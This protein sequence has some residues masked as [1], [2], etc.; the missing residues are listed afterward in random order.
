MKAGMFATK[1]G[2]LVAILAAFLTVEF[3]SYDARADGSGSSWHLNGA[4]NN[5]ARIS[6]NDATCLSAGW[7]NS[8]PASSGVVGGS[9][10]WAR[11]DCSDYGTVVAHLDFKNNVDNHARL[12]GSNRI[13]GD[14]WVNKVRQI[15]C[16]IDESALCWKDQV[17]PKT[18]GPHTGWVRFVIIEGSSLSHGVADVRT[19]QNRYD[20]CQEYPDVIY[21]S[22]DPEGDAH[23]DPNTAAPEPQ[24]VASLDPNTASLEDLRARPCGGEGQP[25]CDCGNRR[26]DRGDCQWS[27]EQSQAATQGE[28]NAHCI[29]PTFEFDDNARK[30][31]IGANCKNGV[32]SEQEGG[33]W[34][35]RWQNV[36]W[37]GRT[38]YADDVLVCWDADNVITLSTS[39][40]GTCG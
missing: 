20:F 32:I 17:E 10:Y 21:C 6:K 28:P 12:S 16:C 15:S 3:T 39:N 13:T 40:T 24:T 14:R 8:P 11:N 33:Q 36:T 30:C 9:T 27:W 19:H 37:R 35:S 29:W 22:L 25:G 38:W 2:M 7:D 1:A 31:V 34:Y 4:C 26:C 18:S 5:W 23:T